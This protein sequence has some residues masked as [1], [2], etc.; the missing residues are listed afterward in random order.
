[1]RS[2]R[3][4]LLLPLAIFMSIGMGAAFLLVPSMNREQ[5]VERQRLLKE[6]A[7]AAA[8]G[9]LTLALHR[10][11]D[12]TDLTLGRAKAEATWSDQ[13]GVKVVT[14]TARVPSLRK[15]EVIVSL[16]TEADTFFQTR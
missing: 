4:L 13:A 12:V 14:A 16:S 6:Q 8:E 3:G 9:A 5:T 7:R 10:G 2:E 11:E 15:G 1:M